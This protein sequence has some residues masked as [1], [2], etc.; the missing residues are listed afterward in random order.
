MARAKCPVNTDR[1]RK[2]L[3]G[4]I[5]L[6]SYFVCFYRP[7]YSTLVSLLTVPNFIE[8]RT[9]GGGKQISTDLLIVRLRSAKLQN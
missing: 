3:V 7:F 6:C 2:I 9:G 5:L 4:D 1:E 8:E